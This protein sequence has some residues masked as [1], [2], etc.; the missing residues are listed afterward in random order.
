MEQINGKQ[1]TMHGKINFMLFVVFLIIH[2]LKIRYFITLHIAINLKKNC[3]VSVEGGIG[4]STLWPLLFV[5]GYLGMFYLNAIF[6][7]KYNAFYASILGALA[8]PLAALIMDWKAIVGTDNVD[9]ISW[10]TFVGFLLI[11]IGFLIK[12]KP[13]D[14][15]ENIED[16]L[17]D[18]LK[19]RLLDEENNTNTIF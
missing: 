6:I 16:N 11:F 2:I 1:L 18:K 14:E 7:I 17:E 12:G 8:A 10:Y 9:P 4:G 15:L 3:Y 5:F 13:E 19:N